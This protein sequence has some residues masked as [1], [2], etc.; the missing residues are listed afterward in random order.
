MRFREGEVY[1]HKYFS[2]GNES[3]Y[4][5][6]T[7]RLRYGSYEITAMDLQTGGNVLLTIGQLNEREF[8]KLENPDD[9]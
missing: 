1:R 4:M 6:L 2:Q 9:V 7:S 8:T 3:Y 5:I